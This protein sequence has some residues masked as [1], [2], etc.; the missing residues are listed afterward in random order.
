MERV[1]ALGRAAG[2]AGA[3]NDLA[4]TSVKLYLDLFASGCIFQCTPVVAKPWVTIPGGEAQQ[5]QQL[6]KSLKQT[7]E[8]ELC[9]RRGSLGKSMDQETWPV[10]LHDS[11]STP[12]FLAKAQYWVIL[13]SHTPCAKVS[14]CSSATQKLQNHPEF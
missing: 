6:S 1:S 13:V 12:L 7:L 5:E 4:S 11:L 10:S 14:Q 8:F 3:A 2:L 9:S